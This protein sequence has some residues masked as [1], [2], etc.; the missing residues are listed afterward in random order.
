MLSQK[1]PDSLTG[2]RQTQT[3]IC[4]SPFFIISFYI[5]TKA[6]SERNVIHICRT[7]SYSKKTKYIV[8]FN[9]KLKMYNIK[10]NQKKQHIICINLVMFIIYIYLF[11]YYMLTFNLMDLHVF[12]VFF[13]KLRLGQ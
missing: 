4:I 12:V 11:K 2:I 13:F 10:K 3:V 6:H 7:E 8:N 5:E 9:S 1:I